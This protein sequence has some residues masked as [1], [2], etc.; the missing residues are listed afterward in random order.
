[1]RKNT[2]CLLS[3]KGT[4]YLKKLDTLFCSLFIKQKN[5][6]QAIPGADTKI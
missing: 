3:Q 1:M 5:W 6:A 4:E 2:L